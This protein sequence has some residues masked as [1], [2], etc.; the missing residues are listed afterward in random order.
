MLSLSSVLL[1]YFIPA[2]TKLVTVS[3]AES[4]KVV[5]AISSF[6]GHA[7]GTIKILFFVECS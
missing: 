7:N 1:P 2:Q 4:C 5:Q 6:S 3:D